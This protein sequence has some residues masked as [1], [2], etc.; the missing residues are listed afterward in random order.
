MEKQSSSERLENETERLEDDAA[1]TEGELK[2]HG[3]ELAD[4]IEQTRADWKRK[5]D[6][7]SVPGAQ[8]QQDD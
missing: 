4:D 8:P 1:G 6:D 3:D 5:Q 7:S 2:Q